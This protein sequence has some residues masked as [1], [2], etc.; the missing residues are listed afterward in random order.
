MGRIETTLREEIARLARREARNLQARHVED[1]RRLKRRVAELGNELDALKGERAV[2][3]S[4]SRMAEATK[5]VAAEKAAKARLSPGLIKK[6]RKRLKISQPE[7][8]K[9]LGVSPAAVGF[10]ESGKSNPRVE[11]KTR[12]VA[13]RNLGRRDVRR[14]LAEA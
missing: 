8:A 6:L 14:L 4:K 13:L 7:L 5:S 1:L 11:T 3:Q 10:W 12:I 9:L 2:E